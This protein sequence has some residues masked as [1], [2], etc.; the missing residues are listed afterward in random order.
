VP[1]AVRAGADG[2]VVVEVFAPGRADWGALE[3]LD[4]SR[5]AWPGDGVPAAQV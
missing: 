4:P 2:A 1:H 3:R 5:P